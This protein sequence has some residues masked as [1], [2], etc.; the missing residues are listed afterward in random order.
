MSLRETGDRVSV[1]PHTGYFVETPDAEIYVQEFGLANKQPVVLIH[2]TGS[3]SQIWQ[4]TIPVLEQRY[5]IIVIDIPPFGYSEKIE[6]GPH[7]YSRAR[8]AQRLLEV[9][10]KLDLTNI[11]LVGH[12]VGSRPVIEAVVKDSSRIQKLVLVDAALGFGDGFTGEFIQA[13]PIPLVRV[14]F[15]F[16]PLRNL[17][18]ATYGT[19]PWSIEPLFKSFVSRKDSVTDMWLDILRAPL[20]VKGTTNAQADWL[21]YLLTYFDDGIS[22]NISALQ[23]VAIPVELIWGDLDT[24]TP[25]S[26][27]QFLTSLFKDARLHIMSGVGHIP[28]VEDVETF[29]ELLS[30][31]IQ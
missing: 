6:G 24:V 29:N 8:Q 2:G 23:N 17:L 28:Y 11:I 3:W 12:S 30:Q 9:F 7:M 13:Q 26:Q 15:G 22:T 5:R 19:S 10:E 14:V 18:L 16:D 25:L 20:I 31:V 21:E 1:A 27:G 4:E